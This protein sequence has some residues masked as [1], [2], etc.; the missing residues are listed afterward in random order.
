MDG[1][2]IRTLILTNVVLGAVL[3]FV[4]LIYARSHA[5]FSGIKTLASGYLYLTVGFFGLMLRDV[6]PDVL[7]IVAANAVVILGIGRIIYGSLRF[8]QCSP[9]WFSKLNSAIA[10]FIALSFWYFSYIHKDINLRIFI[11]SAAN[12]LLLGVALFALYTRYQKDP[13][14]RIPWMSITFALLLTFYS[15]RAVWSFYEVELDSF[16][17]A[18]VIHGL[19]MLSFQFFMIIVGVSILFASSLRLQ[20]TLMEQASI[21]SLTKI[22]NRRALEEAGEKEISRTMRQGVWISAIVVDIDFFKPL[23]DKYGHQAGDV[24]LKWFASILKNNIRDHDVLARY[25]GE[26]FVVLLPDTD[27]PSALVVAEKL[28]SEIARANVM[29]GKTEHLKLTASF[30]VSSMFGESANWFTLI[31]SADAALYEAKN[32]GRNCVKSQVTNELR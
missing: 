26:E 27:L 31:R 29:F 22:Y 10:I 32:S 23:N 6:V 19:T 9:K 17:Q 13:L 18:G 21:D 15:F 4:L 16:M 28:R 24:V 3:G 2:D 12:V 14:Y 5:A 1:L 7:T 30:G 25:G 8:Y 11:I 20:K